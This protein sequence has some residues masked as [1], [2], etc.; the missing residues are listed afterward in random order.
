MHTMM[1]TLTMTSVILRRQSLHN[2]PVD[3]FNLEQLGTT[4]NNLE[5]LGTTW[6]LMK[7]SLCVTSPVI[8]V[9]EEL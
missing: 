4:W 7:I 1:H 3:V 8:Q 5:Q 6:K 2:V 9:P